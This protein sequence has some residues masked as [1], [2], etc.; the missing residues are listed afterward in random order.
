MA[1]RPALP[2]DSSAI[3]AFLVGR[4]DT[5][6]FLRAN[7]AEHGPCGGEARNATRMWI[8]EEEGAVTGVFGITTAGFLLVQVPEALPAE[9]VGILAPYRINGIF[10]A[11]E[12]VREMRARLGLMAAETQLDD[13]EPLY[14]LD[15]AAL[16]PPA[17]TTRLRAATATDL[18]LLIRWRTDYLV[19]IFHFAEA[20]AADLAKADVETMLD[21]RSLMLLEEDGQPVAMTSF[22]A[23]LKDMVQIGS[24]FTP[25]AARGR[26]HAR[27]AV[28]LHLEQ[29]RRV[30][31]KRAILFASGP[32][33]S[34]AYEAIGFRQIGH[35]T[36]LF[37]ADTQSVRAA[38]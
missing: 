24:V 23:I 29:A 21:R 32:A 8:R 5:S 28:A 6:M 4:S 30:G 26:G 27:R 19:E 37:F 20:D 10:G 34:R 38:A 3:E 25:E 9:V 36:L 31:V 14:S 16:M 2:A 17:G 33:A 18:P 11:T 22:N 13:D 12:Q 35:F 15:L 7:L 1:F